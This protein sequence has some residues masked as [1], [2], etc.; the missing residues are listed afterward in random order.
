MVL[1]GEGQV[2]KLRAKI[3]GKP[4]H[5]AAGPRLC[6]RRRHQAGSYMQVSPVD[7]SHPLGLNMQAVG[8]LTA[9]ASHV[10]AA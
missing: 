5:R 8:W 6:C 10:L 1:W 2:L 4:T 9:V 3:A 7:M